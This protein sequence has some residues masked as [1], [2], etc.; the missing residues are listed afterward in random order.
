M[1]TIAPND[2]RDAFGLRASHATPS[3]ASAPRRRA[4]DSA[5]RFDRAKKIVRRIARPS[6]IGAATAWRDR[7]SRN[8]RR[9]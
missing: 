1:R 9:N 5:R 6:K 8:A 3:F 7:E 4:R 2:D